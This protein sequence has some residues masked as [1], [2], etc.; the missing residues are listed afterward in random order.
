MSANA[1]LKCPR[2]VK[3]HAADIEQLQQ[4]SDDAY[5][6]VSIDEWKEID[7][8]VAKAR[9]TETPCDF[10]VDHDLSITSEGMVSYRMGGRCTQCD[11][12]VLLEAD[13]RMDVDG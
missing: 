2:C 11:L 4:A 8:A 10:R 6:N 12:K 1:W 5:G 13:K 3:R 7:A 9:L